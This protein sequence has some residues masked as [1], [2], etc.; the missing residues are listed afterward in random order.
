M[1]LPNISQE[2]NILRELRAEKESLETELEEKYHGL[3]PDME[4]AA[5]QV[6]ESKRRY[7][8]LQQKLLSQGKIDFVDT[9]LTTCE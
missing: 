4:E 9:K 2:L 1:H 7:I 5:K 8:E 6:E 3:A